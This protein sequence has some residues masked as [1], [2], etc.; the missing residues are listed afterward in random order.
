MNA[1]LRFIDAGYPRD[2]F[3]TRLYDNL[4]TYGGFGFIA[5]YDREGF[6]EE[7]F[8]TPERQERFLVDLQRR[9]ER[10]SGHDRP[11][12]WCDVK[13]ALAVHLSDEPETVPRRVRRVAPFL[14]PEEEP[15][16]RSSA[17][18]LF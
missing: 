12:L 13:E 6:Y 4:A 18:T 2:K 9:C 5:H 15:P 10:E 3:T 16:E 17:P 7:K 14:S 11:D 8:S 1:L